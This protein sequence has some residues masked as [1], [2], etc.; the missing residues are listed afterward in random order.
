[1]KIIDVNVIWLRVPKLDQA[2]EWGEDAVIVKIT[3]DEGLVGY[4]ESDSCPLVI[5]SFIETPASHS[6]CR[7][8]RDILIGKNPLEISLLWDEMFTGSEYMGR[9]GAGIHAISAIDIALWDIAGQF[10]GVPVHTLLGGKYR[11]KIDAYGTFIPSD[12]D[13]ESCEKALNL[14]SQGFRSIKFGGNNFGVNPA[15]DYETVR[16]IRETVGNDIDIEIDLVGLWKNYSLAKKRY[17]LLKD[18]NINWI[19]EPVPSDSLKCYRRLSETL[20]VKIT[21]GESLTS[22]SEFKQF[23]EEASPAIVQPDIT[24]CGGI[25]EIRKI[26]QLAEFNGVS[27]VPHG[28]STGILLH[29]TIHFLASTRFGELIEYSQSNSPIYKYLVKNKIP[30]IDGKVTVPDKPGLG[31]ELDNDFIKE[32]SVVN[33]N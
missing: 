33:F 5:K 30:V 8:L 13:D 11:E 21:G 7:G 10:Y 28:F 29:A 15:N 3:T 9:R 6:T 22:Y 27:L 26:N 1:M 2:C 23:I 25:S 4:G 20:P 16:R 24:R 18:F 12:D 17:E 19:E 31:L 14:L 32:Y